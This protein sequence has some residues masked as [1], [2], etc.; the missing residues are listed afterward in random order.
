MTAAHECHL[1]AAMSLGEALESVRSKVS[2]DRFEILTAERPDRWIEAKPAGTGRAA[3]H[4]AATGGP[5]DI[6]V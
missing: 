3:S 5:P 6:P 2:A 1:L 4:P